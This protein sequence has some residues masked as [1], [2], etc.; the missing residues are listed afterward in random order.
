MDLVEIISPPGKIVR[1]TVVLNGSKSIANRVQVIRALCGSDFEI[2]NLSNADDTIILEKLLSSEDFIL[3]AGAG[4]TTYRFLS[5]YLST[6]QGQEYLL[7]GSARMQQRPISILVEALRKLGAD[8]TYTHQEGFPPLLIKGKQLHGGELIIPANTSSQFISALLLIAPYLQGGLRLKLEGEIVS[9]PYISM[10]LRIMACFGVNSDFSGNT[11]TVNQA[12]Y[13]AQ[14]FFVEADW[15]AA[16]YYYAIAA[17]SEEAEIALKGLSLESFQGDAVIAAIMKP[18]GVETVYGEHVITIRK[19]PGFSAYPALIEFDFV[20]CPDLAQTVVVVCAALGIPGRFKGLQTL[21]IKETDR[22]AAL[23][24]E[25]NKFGASFTRKN[26]NIWEL[27]VSKTGIATTSLP[28]IATYDDHRMA[29]A[30][31]PMALLTVS[32]HIE[33]PGVVSKSY[34]AYW[35]DLS[36]LGFQLVEH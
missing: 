24:N 26:D 11:I 2:E 1:G 25:L 8:I 5:A 13:K 36:S 14:S 28:S 29:M 21:L 34:P 30:F 23:N 32:M 12:A 19:R 20:A 18:F 35:K 3:D 31:A 6:L 10:T 33:E 17:L 15:S 7:T 27:K 9:R 4:G 22:V 16:S